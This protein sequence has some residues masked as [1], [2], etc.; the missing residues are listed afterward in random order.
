MQTSQPRTSYDED[1]EKATR[2]KPLPN[3]TDRAAYHAPPQTSTIRKVTSQDAFYD[4]NSEQG[5][6]SPD[7][8]HLV[9]NFSK[10]NVGRSLNRETNAVAYP[11]PGEDR[12]VE[13]DARNHI[14]RSSLDKPL[15]K[16]PVSG[17]ER[18]EAG[19]IPESYDQT[20]IAYTKA[21]DLERELGVEGQIDLSNTTDVEVLERWAP[22]VTHETITRNIH[23]IREE[24]ITRDIHQDHYFHRILPIEE[25][26]T[27]R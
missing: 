5:R 22:A 2:R 23:E 16:P 24:Q 6:R 1:L 25:V 9:P 14:P 8:D 13:T 17:A 20:S 12:G 7:V 3:E 11:V 19:D 18:D 27:L 15:P 10:L 21:R 26:S 4:C